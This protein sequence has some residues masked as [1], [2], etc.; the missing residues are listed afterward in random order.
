MT[1]S[2]LK[3]HSLKGFERGT[4]G[5]KKRRTGSD[6]KWSLKSPKDNTEVG[7]LIIRILMVGVFQECQ[8]DIPSHNLDR[9]H[10]I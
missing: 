5:K 9:Y 3:V 1:K 2:G 4:F 8:T 6:I 7:D 10:L